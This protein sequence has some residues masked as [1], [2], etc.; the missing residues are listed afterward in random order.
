MSV[1]T[2]SSVN[3]VKACDINVCMLLG[4]AD[5]HEHYPS[6]DKGNFASHNRQ[7]L[8]AGLCQQYTTK[9]GHFWH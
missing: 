7:I 2:N 9:L 8:Q 1:R 3:A 6:S 5:K 4:R